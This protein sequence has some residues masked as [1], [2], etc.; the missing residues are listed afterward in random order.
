MT[1]LSIKKQQTLLKKVVFVVQNT[2]ETKTSISL[3]SNK[4]YSV[5]FTKLKNNSSNCFCAMLEGALSITSLPALFLGNA[6]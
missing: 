5:G 6:M 4:N 2:N 1:T 3:D